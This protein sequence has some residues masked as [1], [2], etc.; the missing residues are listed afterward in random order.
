MALG[1]ELILGVIAGSDVI[2]YLDVVCVPLGRI[3]VRLRSLAEAPVLAQ[4]LVHCLPALAGRLV[5]NGGCLG[6]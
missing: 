6:G 5:L 4:I 3:L 2:S 1:S